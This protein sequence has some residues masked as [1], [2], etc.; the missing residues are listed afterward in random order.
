MRSQSVPCKASPVLKNVL[1]QDERDMA[2]REV[3]H[4]CQKGLWESNGHPADGLLHTHLLQ[5]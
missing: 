2:A 5:T 1:G 3:V 4:F